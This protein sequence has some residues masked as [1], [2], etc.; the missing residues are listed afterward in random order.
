[1]GRKY[2]VARVTGNRVCLLLKLAEK[3]ITE[4]RLYKGLCSHDLLQKG[5][6]RKGRVLRGDI[7]PAELR[8]NNL[9]VTLGT[10]IAPFIWVID[11]LA[12]GNSH[13]LLVYTNSFEDEFFYRKLCQAAGLE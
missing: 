5:I 8:Q 13:V 4:G 7:V 2:S 3:Q 10:G 1:M 11:Q 12:K 6:L 9:I